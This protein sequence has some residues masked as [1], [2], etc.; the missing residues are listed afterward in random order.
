[1]LCNLAS[2]FF[3]VSEDEPFHRAVS[4]MKDSG[5]PVNVSSAE[6]LDQAF[7]AF[8][9]G[10]MGESEYARHLRAR[11]GWKGSDI[12]LVSMFSQ[13]PQSVHL[14]MVDALHRLRAAGWS[15]VGAENT[16]PWQRPQRLAAYAHLDVTPRTIFTSL[17][18]GARLPDLGF[19]ER[20]FGRLGPIQGSVL[21]VDRDVTNVSAARSAGLD[22]HLLRSTTELLTYAAGQ[23]SRAA[24]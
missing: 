7:T 20:V 21:F 4:Y 1:M 11:L 22:A 10:Y 17:D 19:F 8:Q 16:T 23:P 18:V 15:I 9:T 13:H 14:G 3:G 5:V 24:L 6:L 12:E 2:S